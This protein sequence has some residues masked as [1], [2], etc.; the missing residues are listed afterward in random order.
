M[1]RPPLWLLM[2]G[3]VLLI[4]AL[5]VVSLSAGRIN[6][7]WSA[8]ISW[9]EDP[10]WS[11]V[12]DLR[13]PRTLLA[14][15]VGAALGAAGAALQ[16]YVRNPLADPGTLGVSQIAAFAA[17]MTIYLG[18][19]A[20][21]PWLLF[22]AAILG[23]MIGVVALL[24]LAGASSS[25]TTFV[26][27]GAILTTI[28]SAGVALALTLAP[29]P[30][31]VNEIINWLMGS[32]ADR[33][34]DDVKL[35]APFI[36]VGL[37]LLMLTGPALDALTLGDT[38]AR[39]LGIDMT[40]TRGLVAAGVGLTVGAAVAAT[41]IISFVGLVTPHLIRPLVGARPR[42][43]LAPSALAGAALV[44]AAD[45]LVRVTPSQTEVRLGVAMAALGG[46]FFLW[47][48]LSMRRRMA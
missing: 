18:T 48:L 15:L 41:G 22:T 13:L 42:A 26:L 23:A 4:A 44:L 39:A 16:G 35:A 19:A 9:G 20:A 43:L 8:W 37:G 7:P 11:I 47:L 38:G 6:V 27:A 29:S 32:L 31:A 28:G 45:I 1:R 14:I 2:T 25:V 5:S 30:W 21:V 3:L 33:S 10:R 40:S 17:V 34:I 12:F 24:L 36:L 46:P